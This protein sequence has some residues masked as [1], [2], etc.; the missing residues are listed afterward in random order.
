MCPLVCPPVSFAVAVQASLFQSVTSAIKSDS[1]FSRSCHLNMGQGPCSMILGVVPA[2][3]TEPRCRPAFWGRAL[4]CRE[5]GYGKRAGI[6]Y[7]REHTKPVGLDGSGIARRSRGL[8]K[9][10]SVLDGL[11]FQVTLRQDQQATRAAML[12]GLNAAAN[13]LSSGDFFVFLYSGHGGQ[14]PDTSGD[15]EDR[16]DEVYL[17]FDREILDDEL[18][19][20]W[21]KFKSGVRVVVLTD[22]CHSGTGLRGALPPASSTRGAAPRAVMAPKL[23]GLGLPAATRSATRSRIRRPGESD[24]HECVPRRTDRGRHKPWWCLHPGPHPSDE[25]ILRTT[26]NF[27]SRL[28]VSLP[29][30]GHVQISQLNQKGPG[31]Q[32]FVKQRPFDLNAKVDIQLSSATKTKIEE[33]KKFT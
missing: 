18:G 12:D 15:D 11:S 30:G 19:V 6:D 29:A 8:Q 33:G 14:R 27:I 17:P 7:R 5:W 28:R 21:P 13:E 22:S 3:S 1:F 32:D 9:Y 25:R 4:L 23:L 24:P 2:W 20:I 16:L 26:R 31:V 10:G